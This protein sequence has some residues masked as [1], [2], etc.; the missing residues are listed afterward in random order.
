MNTRQI[1]R[2][3]VKAD[4]FTCVERLIG[5]QNMKK[6]S[7]SWGTLFLVTFVAAY[8]YTFNEWLFAITRPY[9]MNDLSL[10]RQLQ[11]FFTI[12]ALLVSLCFLG[13]LPLVLLSLLPPLK[14]YTDML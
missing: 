10:I 2:T 9:F 6:T 14:K 3:A 1:N 4:C 5:S 13:L 11:I 12:S 7:L 8:L